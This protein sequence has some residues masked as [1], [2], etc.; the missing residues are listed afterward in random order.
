LITNKGVTVSIGKSTPLDV[1]LKIA[2][3]NET[4]SVQAQTEVLNTSKA[5]TGGLFTPTQVTSLPLG[6]RNFLNLVNLET[7]VRSDSVSGHQSFVINGAP[8]QQGIQLHGGRY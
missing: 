7:G 6:G 4:I 2:T 8:P 1:A 5:E 3:T